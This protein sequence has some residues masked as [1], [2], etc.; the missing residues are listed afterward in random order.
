MTSI[1]KVNEIQDAGGNTILSSNGTGTFTSSLPDNTPAFSAYLSTSQSFS[2]NTDTKVNMTSENYDTNNAYDAANS[3]FTIPSGEGGKYRFL[4]S[5][6][7][8]NIHTTRFLGMIWK[9]GSAVTTAENRI[10]I[11]GGTTFISVNFSIDI[12][13]IAGDYFEPY[14]Y[15]TDSA[16]LSG[17]A[18]NQITVWSASK[19]IGV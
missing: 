12:N 13:C 18:T 1:I 7:T 17:S 4:F 14:V 2:V 8:A 10:A 16:G 15:M 5:A 6:R 3:K 19:L 9:N 11:G